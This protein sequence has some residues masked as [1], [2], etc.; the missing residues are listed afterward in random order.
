MWPV[1]SVV[2]RERGVGGN[3]AP[4]AF[5]SLC[6]FLLHASWNEDVKI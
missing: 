2:S 1:R 6:S 4:V 3:V 5:T